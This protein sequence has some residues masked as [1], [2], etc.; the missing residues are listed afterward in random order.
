MP[1]D[2]Q[3]LIGRPYAFPSDPPRSWDCWSLVKWVRAQSGLAS[4][5]PFDDAARW[6]RPEAL[7]EAVRRARGCWQA[8]PEPRQFAM[9]VLDPSHVGVVVD[10]GVL[11][12]LASHSG[13]LWTRLGVARRRW[14]QVEWWEAA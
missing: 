12:A 13:V 4:P 8:L 3:A 2:L 9:A 1:P 7:P 14:P 5:L 10:G 6:C 11:H